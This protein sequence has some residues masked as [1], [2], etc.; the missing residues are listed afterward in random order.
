MSELKYLRIIQAV[1]DTPWAI[2]P[3][4]LE[5]ITSFLS[6]KASGLGIAGIDFEALAEKNKQATQAR[7]QKY[8]GVLP[9]HGT[10]V[11]RASFFSRA[12][13][14]MSVE[15]FK[16]QFDA[17]MSDSSVSAIVFD[18][19]SPG[20]AI[21]GVPELSDYIHGARGEKPIIA[22]V[23]TLM[24]S[25]AYW[26]ASAADEIYMTPSGRVGSIGVLTAHVD[27]SQKEEKDGVKVTVLSAGKHKAE[28]SPHAPLSEEAR[29]NA[30]RMVDEYYSM[31]VD[32][33]ARN[34]GVSSSVVRSGFGEGRVVGASEAL[35]E[36]MIDGVESFDETLGRLAID[37]A[38]SSDI[39]A[40]QSPWRRNLAERRLDK[41]K[42]H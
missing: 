17:L 13:G 36:G 27:R 1:E 39:D 15:G 11:N 22:H 38:D 14:L 18:T 2:L 19:D 37:S 29:A 10:I 28:L 3:A 30:Q 4:K 33:V 25:A 32:A 34:R 23:N 12:S 6:H 41:L 31:F 26:I 21:D 9:L 5:E 42:S 35:D 16:E 20:G 8:I 7:K 24:A 40:S